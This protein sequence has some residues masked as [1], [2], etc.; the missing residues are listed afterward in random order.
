MRRSPTTVAYLNPLSAV[1]ETID[2]ETYLLPF[3]TAVHTY[4]LTRFETMTIRTAFGKP[5]ASF[6]FALVG[7]GFDM[8]FFFIVRLF[9]CVYRLSKFCL[10]IDTAEFV[11]EEGQ[12]ALWLRGCLKQRLPQAVS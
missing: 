5:E 11:G 7:T 2:T 8:L 10:L 6:F 3:V 9:L 12:L 4:R 1:G